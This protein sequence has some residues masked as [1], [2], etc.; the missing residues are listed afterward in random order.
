M[1][2][3]NSSKPVILI[4]QEPKKSQQNSH[5][6]FPINLVK[7]IS[8]ISKDNSIGASEAKAKLKNQLKS[9]FGTNMKQ[10]N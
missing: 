7:S 1:S 9:A 4:T 6:A 3:L 5:E 10:P 2:N 8:E